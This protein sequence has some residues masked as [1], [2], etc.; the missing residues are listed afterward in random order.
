MPHGHI[1]VTLAKPYTLGYIRLFGQE[2]EI[3]KYEIQTITVR[4]KSALGGSFTLNVTDYLGASEIAG[5][6]G[7]QL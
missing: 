2:E 3:K 7:I 1:Q 6:G 4:S 5:E